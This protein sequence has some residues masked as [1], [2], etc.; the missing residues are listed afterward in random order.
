M[1]DSILIETPNDD[2]I[3]SIGSI[4]TDPDGN[5]YFMDRQQWKLISFSADGKFR[6]MT[7]QEG[8]GP[9]DF[10]RVRGIV[11][12]GKNLFIG[13]IGGSRIDKFSFDGNFI[14]SIPMSKDL[15]F[16]SLLKFSE[17]GS[18]V[19]S[20]TVWASFARRILYTQ[21][22]EDSLKLE[23]EFILIIRL[24]SKYRKV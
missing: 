11:T 17:K 18:L 1:I 7:G 2:V 16:A 3:A 4:I 13:N 9:G 12:D 23:T 10:E 8:K 22:V 5:I 20:S 6:W 14:K 15:G 19:I 21:L 24:I